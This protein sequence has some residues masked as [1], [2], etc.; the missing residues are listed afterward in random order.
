MKII[1]HRGYWL[2]AS[3]KNTPRA[4][5]RSFG[6]GFGTETD[7][8]DSLGRLVISHD[9]PSG[10]EQEFGEFLACAGCAGDNKNPLTLAL[11]IKADGLAQLLAKQ[12]ANI[13]QLDCFVFDMA[14]PDMR[15]YLTAGIPVFT[16]MSEVERHPAYLDQADGVWLD[17]FENEWYDNS[18]IE[19]L[20][21][22]GKRVCIVSP[23]LH[24]RPFQN[25]WDQLSVWSDTKQ[26]I[27]CTDKPEEAIAYFGRALL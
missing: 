13:S 19:N 1:S 2:N 7:I 26:V 16:R 9:M 23:E 17:A 25:H 15:Q 3:E 12:L 11:N 5:E 22:L 10:N 20:I 8:R 18:I 6:L 14:I 27:L 21:G 24:A 4:F